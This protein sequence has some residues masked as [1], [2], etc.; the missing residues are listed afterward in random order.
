M[1]TTAHGIIYPDATGSTSLWE[2]YQNVATTTET[3]LTT[4]E[5]FNT[6]T[7]TTWDT[8]TGGGFTSVGGSGTAEGFYMR[9][10]NFV[11]AEFRIELASGFATDSGTFALQLPV[12]AYAWGGAIIQSTLGTWTARD[13]SGPDHWSGSIGL[14][15][16]AATHVSF[17]GAW[18][19]GAPNKRIDSNDPIVWAS[20]DMLSGT[21]NYRSA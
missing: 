4:Y 11:H 2:H 1:V 6:W 14:W 12:A 19:A 15:N 5:T 20:G 7:P 10:G 8:T 3:A 16:T 13:N 21:L 17:N 9:I 18:N